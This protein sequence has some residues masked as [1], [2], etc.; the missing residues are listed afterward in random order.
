[1]KKNKMMR[2]ASALLVA[3]LLTT[4]AISGT[5][6]KYVT[7]VS[8]SDSARVAKWN[9]G[10]DFDEKSTFEDVYSNG[11]SDTVD[12]NDDTQVVAPGTTDSGTYKLLGQPET[13]YKVNFKFVVDKEIFLKAGTYDFTD[14]TYTEMDLTLGDNYIPLTWKVTVTAPAGAT[15]A[16]KVDSGVA[17]LV[18]GE[19]NF[20]TM[21]AMA[22]AI[23]NTQISYAANAACDLTVKIEW[24]WNFDNGVDG[25]KADTILGYLANDVAATN[26]MLGASLV[27]DT[28]FCTNVGYTFSMTAEQ[29]D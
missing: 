15:I 2:V 22:A 27:A 6:A 24:N 13:A 7:T 8:G 1:M 16:K 3:V 28:D 20:T 10:F 12:S 19:N 21:S 17:C 26:T 25:N 29:V 18:N 23:E 5:F 11:V 4:C 14:V 9:F